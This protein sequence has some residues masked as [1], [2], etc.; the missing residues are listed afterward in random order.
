MNFKRILSVSLCS[1]MVLSMV[2]CAN[3]KDILT[4]IISGNS[5][6]NGSN[7]N[8]VEEAQKVNKSAVFKE[9][10]SF[11]PEGFDYIDGLK[12]VNGKYYAGSLIYQYPEGEYEGPDGETIIYDDEK[13]PVDDADVSEIGETKEEPVDDIDEEVIADEGIYDSEEYEDV[14]Y[15][16]TVSLKIVSFTNESDAS[17]VEL[18]LPSNEYFRGGDGWGVDNEGNIIVV[19]SIY[20]NETGDET[21]FLRKY[22]PAGEELKAVEIETDIQYYYVGSISIDPEGNIYVA[23]DT[24]IYVYDKDLNKNE[25]A[26]FESATDSYIGQVFISGE[27]ELCYAE[28]TWKE[29]GYEYHF[30]KVGKNGNVEED[31]Y[32]NKMLTNKEL[33]KG[34]GYDYYYRTASSVKAFNKG[35]KDAVEV[36]NFYD[37]DIDP[38]SMSGILLFK[39]AESFV[40]TGDNNII[41][42][43]KVPE[44]QVVEKEILTL[45]SVYGSYAVQ[46][47]ILK[48]NKENDKYRIKLIDYSEY[49]T[50]DDWYAGQKRFNTDITGGNT[51]DIIVPE[52]SDALNL[53]NK[54][55]I[56]DMSPM[57]EAGNGI[58]KDDLVYNAQNAFAKDGKLYFLFPSFEV[59]AFE[60]KK[61]NYKEGM[62]FDDIIAWE[63]ETGKQA[64]GTE[65]TKEGMLN[66]LM[67]QS[68]NAFLDPET[69]K[70][71]FDSDEFIKI[72]EY[73]NNYMTEFPDDYWENYDYQA[74]LNLFR[75]DNALISSNYL[76]SFRDYNWNA[77]Y[78][79]GAETV[80]IGLP[81]EGS[82]GTVLN[83]SYLIGISDKCK[84]KDAAWDFVASCFSD[85]YYEDNQ[86]VFPSLEKK[87][88][89]MIEEATQKPYWTD[90]NGQK[91]YYDESF[92]LGDE[93]VQVEPITKEKA[94]ELKEFVTHVCTV[95]SWDEELNKI[96]D[97]ETQGYF[98]GQKS[99]KEVA[100]IIQSR[101]Q[102]Y[103]NEKK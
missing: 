100:G 95:Y 50:P 74:Y 47:Q 35:D 102:I 17:Y 71:N 3:P 80:V 40:C 53:I 76:Y 27:G 10:A 79:F 41:F 90:E 28:E 9:A 44:D 6:N 20:D 93:E 85:D 58:K 94:L 63:E 36:C 88:D 13:I 24:S 70:C 73:S 61:S 15:D 32:L 55:A 2:G 38:D 82:E 1:A 21:Y 81:I 92:W 56:A 11:I 51:P 103:I 37:S 26:S 39:D 66:N 67:S 42:Y 59:E 43:E 34:N 33:V 62:T 65:Y 14:D 83:P 77:K 78:R 8:I 97:E 5:N 19:S 72:L 87:M 45:G 30:Y 99:A 96:V 75:E 64:F 60:I 18:T 69:G 86:Y 84:D 68:M 29:S 16:V 89:E 57:M 12:Y 48:F 49:N 98:K 25:A 7:V 31:T 22:S 4:S 46:K 23:S 101:L 91:V 52:A 54:G